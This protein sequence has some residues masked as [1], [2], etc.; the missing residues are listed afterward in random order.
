MLAK[1]ATVNNPTLAMIGEA[2]PETV[3]PHNNKPRSRALL[4]QAAAGV[5]VTGGGDTY[6]SF[7]PVIHGGDNIKQQISEAEDEF[8]RRMDSYFARKKRIAYGV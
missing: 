2:G 5:G 6:I 3:V 1:G 4:A 8:E 7:S